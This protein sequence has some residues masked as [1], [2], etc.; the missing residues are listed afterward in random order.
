MRSLALS[1]AVLLAVLVASA[2]LPTD[3]AAQSPSTISGTVRNGTAGADPPAG[4]RVTLSYQVASGEL[5]EHDAITALDGSFTYT[6][7]PPQGLPGFEVRTDYLDVEY[8]NRVLGEPL[9]GPSDLT[10][11]ELT[12]DFSVPLPSSTTPSP[13]PAPTAA[14]AS[15]P[16]WRPRSSAT[17]A[18][19]PSAPTC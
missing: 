2:A 18:T 13:S 4:L 9:S 7:L 10:V 5:V 8:A 6:D 15:S 11:Y 3:A 17:P 16:C 1:V 12:N 14:S 19:A